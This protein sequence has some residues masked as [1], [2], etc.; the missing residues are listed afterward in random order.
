MRWRS[1]SSRRRRRRPEGSSGSRYPE[2]QRAREPASQIIDR[3]STS[4]VGKAG[5]SPLPHQNDMDEDCDAGSR[6]HRQEYGADFGPGL[7]NDAQQKIEYWRNDQQQ[8]AEA[9]PDSY[10]DRGTHQ[11][12]C[13]QDNRQRH[14]IEGHREGQQGLMR[15]S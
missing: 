1:A 10:A 3:P 15:R 7:E 4:N 13:R 11:K 6:S 14:E 9:V 2:L 8:I 5:V 12:G